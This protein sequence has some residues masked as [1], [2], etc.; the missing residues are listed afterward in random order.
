[1]LWLMLWTQAEFRGDYGAWIGGNSPC[2]TL[3]SANG[4][5]L[6]E[7]FGRFHSL[8]VASPPRPPPI[9]R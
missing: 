9:P 8:K 7:L 4:A 3:T 6:E 2:R 1:M 5:K